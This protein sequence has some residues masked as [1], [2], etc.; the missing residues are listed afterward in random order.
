MPVYFC[1]KITVQHG[2]KCGGVL[3]DRLMPLKLNGKIYRTVVKPALVYDAGTRASTKSQERRL[4]LNETRMLGW[5][6]G[7]TKTA[8]I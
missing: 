5:M 7:V 3:C 4:E 2:K 1:H 8:K 6:C